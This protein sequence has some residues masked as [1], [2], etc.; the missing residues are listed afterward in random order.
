MGKKIAVR[1]L[2]LAREYLALALRYK[3]E[4][5]LEELAKRIER[6]EEGTH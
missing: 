2:N 5:D 6:I 3:K 1:F 4:Y